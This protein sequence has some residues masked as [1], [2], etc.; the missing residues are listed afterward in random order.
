MS[1]AKIIAA[2]EI[3]T[4]KVAAVVAEVTPKH[5]IS[6]LG[7]GEATSRGV[8][9]GEITDF[10]LTCEAT[11]AA[12]N[13]AEKSAGAAIDAVY[14]A[15]SGRHIEGFYHIGTT[16]INTPNALVSEGD[17]ARV[18]ENAKAKALSEG[19][20]YMHHI[21]NGFLLDGK[22]LENPINHHGQ[23][24]E[25]AY[26]HLHGDTKRVSEA[27]SVV[28]RYGLPVDEIIVSSIAAAQVAAHDEEKKLGCL[29]LDIG[30]GTTNYVVYRKGLIARAGVIAIGGDHFTNDLSNGLRVSIP[31]AESLKKT[32]AK[33]Y[34]EE[35]DKTQQRWLYGDP[36]S[37]NSAIGNRPVKLAAFGQI[38]QPRLEELFDILRDEMGELYDPSQL[39]A[40]VILTG[41]SS[42]LNGLLELAKRRLSLDAKLSSPIP[43][44]TEASLKGPEY[45][46]VLG[47]LYSALTIPSRAPTQEAGKPSLMQKISKLF[48][49]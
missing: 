31:Q 18:V 16:A 17:I 30:A 48:N 20:L 40:G 9:K 6:L 11:H 44:V 34:W 24:L 47:L 19:R 23:K 32:H 39:K 33:A 28:N 25:V 36:I 38:L 14:L 26:W 46:T 12:L 43:W 22:M 45:T 27:I 15:L 8:K 29:V 3:G 37:G 41:G 1:N 42:R 35:A 7:R 13:M 21:K 49:F 5:S 10:R 2:V 4:S